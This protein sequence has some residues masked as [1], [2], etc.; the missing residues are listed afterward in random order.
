MPKQ[1]YNAYDTYVSYIL[2]TCTSV[3]EST[4]VNKKV[5]DRYTLSNDKISRTRPENLIKNMTPLPLQETVEK[6]YSQD[7]LVEQWGSCPDG[8]PWRRTTKQYIAYRNIFPYKPQPDSTNWAL[9]LREKIENDKVN[10]SSFVAE[11]DE[12]CSMFKDAA[13]RVTDMYR[14]L[15][16]G[17]SP[18][19]GRWTTRDV[20]EA[21][22]YIDFGV[23]P[24]LG[25]LTSIIGLMQDKI[26]K[27]IIKRYS[28]TS[29]TEVSGVIPGGGYDG[30][31]KWKWRLTEKPV[32]YVAF[33][34][35]SADYTLGNPLEWAWER[36]PFSFVVDWMIPVGS[37]L[38]SLDAL[39]GCSVYAGCISRKYNAK[40]T[41]NLHRKATSISVVNTCI[42]NGGTV[43]VSH[44]RDL[45]SSVPLPNFPSYDP[46]TSW[47]AVKHGLDLL[48][49]L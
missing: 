24:I 22:L 28:F 48:R 3:T 37:Y 17:K 7:M 4:T 27:P 34:V 41:S 42:K 21:D 36:I 31:E 13:K 14:H 8:L 29:Q 33:D 47:Y 2:R 40:S 43:Y 20:A 44:Q 5:A 11:F 19:K 30:S 39:R 46:S 38:S 26:S 6:Y 10:L 32:V 12:S 25:D 16:K 49:V 35:N 18:F 1:Y 15:R 23:K 9:K 45:I